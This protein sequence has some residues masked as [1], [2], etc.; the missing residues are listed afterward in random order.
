MAELELALKGAGTGSFEWD[1]QTGKARISPEMETL[2]GFEPGGFAGTFEALRE[3][4]HP[5]DRDWMVGAFTRAAE[6]GGPFEVQFR[7]LRHAHLQWRSVVGNVL[8]DAHGRPTRMIGVGRDVT[9]R[10]Q[11]EHARDEAQSR[12]RRLVEQLPLVTYVERLDAASA[13]YISPQIADL[14]GYTAEEWVADANFFGKVLHPDDRD[15][16]LESYVTTHR[17]VEP[18]DD[19]YRLIARDGRTVWVHDEAVIVHDEAGT[20]VSAQ[21]YMIDITARREAEQALR[22]S[23]AQLRRRIAEIEHQSLHD[24]LTGLPNRSLFHD[25]IEQALAAA[26]R[27]DSA[28]AVM[29]IDLDR[30]KEVNDTLG[31][32][33]GDRL[34]KEVGRRLRGV[35]RGSDTVARL[36][37]DEFGILAPGIAN[38]ADAVRVAEKLGLTLMRQ[39]AIGELTLEVEASAGIALY[40]RHGIDV[41]TLIRHA[42]VA[43]YVS[44]ETHHPAVYA[45]EQDQHTTGR[46]NRVADLR[47]AVARDELVVHYQVQVDATTRRPRGMEALLRWQHPRNGLL[48]PDQFIPLA[49]RSGLIRQLTMYALDTAIHQ[50]SVWHE[51]GLDL[52]VAVNVTGRDLLDLGFPDQV[53]ALLAKWHIEPAALELEITENTIFTNATRAHDVLGRLSELGVRL[54]IDDFGKGHSSLEHL[55]R[56]PIDVLKIDRSFVMNMARDTNAVIVRSTIDLA[57]NLG[58]EVVAE[59]VETEAAASHLAALGCDTLQGFLLSRPEPAERLAVVIAAS[60]KVNCRAA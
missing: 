7:T 32:L 52:S 19:E 18:F 8:T 56:L 60:P 3:L 1:F 36:G 23:Q 59:G 28:F 14:V 20:P 17:G 15:R 58:L 49:E 46:L 54:A 12:Y 48:A 35:A 11:A 6:A 41:E 30:F 27:T 51:Q 29:V 33:T 4:V 24:S 16:V 45:P 50:C 5:D 10:H 53:A 57:H 21:G 13:I 40:P 25:R 38:G 34:L 2:H 22:M 37:G 9:E 44:K 47:R 42:D 43:M 31:D 55:A 26:N 39:M